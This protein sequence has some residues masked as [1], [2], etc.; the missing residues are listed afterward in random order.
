MD[1]YVYPP[2]SPAITV[3][4]SYPLLFFIPFIAPGDDHLYAFVC[5]LLK[6]LSI[7]SGP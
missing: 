5:L 6:C 4:I 3:T 2:T 7:A 1:I